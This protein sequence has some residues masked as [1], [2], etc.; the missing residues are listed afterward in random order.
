VGFQPHDERLQKRQSAEG[1]SHAV[2]SAV[3]EK[4]G[5]KITPPGLP[6]PPEEHGE[7]ITGDCIEAQAI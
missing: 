6:L 2:E 5:E 3:K 7:F 4:A 1:A